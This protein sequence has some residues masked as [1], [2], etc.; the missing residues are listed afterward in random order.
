MNEAGICA[1][2]PVTGPTAPLLLRKRGK[3]ASWQTQP[4]K[5]PLR[6]RPTA[7]C[8]S[9]KRRLHTHTRLRYHVEEQ[10][11]CRLY[12]VVRASSAE[13]LGTMLVSDSGALA[14]AHPAVRH[15]RGSRCETVLWPLHLYRVVTGCATTYMWTCD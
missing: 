6:P 8:C 11:T 14:L 12:L 15:D 3:Q 10:A 13:T 5:P 1:P 4:S 7:P 2:D 9:S